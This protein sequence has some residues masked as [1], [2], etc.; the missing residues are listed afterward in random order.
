MAVHLRVLLFL[1]EVSLVLYGKNGT[2]A[3]Q[4]SS[5]VVYGWLYGKK[6]N[7]C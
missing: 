2:D 5:A 7:E 3:S 1:H 6:R 4:Y